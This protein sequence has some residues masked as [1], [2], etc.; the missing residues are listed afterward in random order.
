MTLLTIDPETCNQDGICAAVCPAGIIDFKKGEFPAPSANAEEICIQCGHCVAVCP[1]GSLSHR[2]MATDRCPPIQDGLRLSEAQCEQFLRARRSIRRYKDKPV[3]KEKI[4]RLI[5]LARYAPTGHN[6][7]N[8]KWLALGTRAELDTL[9]GLTVEWMRWLITNEKEMAQAF[10]LE[11]TVQNWEAGH[12]VILRRAPVVIVTH[13]PKTDLGAPTS[14]TLALAYLELA[15]TG[16]GLG[17]CW[18]GYFGRAAATFPP[19]QAALAL[20]DGHQC[21]AAMMVGYPMFKYKRLPTRRTPEI[22][23]RW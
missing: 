9:A 13:A 20:P 17:T 12:D 16:M 11:E 6:L 1:T 7:Q 2:V 14:S 8:V 23:W 5:E 22:I 18:A 4:A 15:A 10:H 3:S 19:L 21:L